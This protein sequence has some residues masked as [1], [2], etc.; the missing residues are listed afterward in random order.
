[1]SY[2]SI[3][4]ADKKIETYDDFEYEELYGYRD[5]IEEVFQ[6]YKEPTKEMIQYIV[7]RI[8]PEQSVLNEPSTCYKMLTHYSFQ[9]RSFLYCFMTVFEDVYDIMAFCDLWNEYAKQIALD[10]NRFCFAELKVSRA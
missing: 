5:L 1:M 2:H 3:R 6:K 7:E 9:Q 8:C 4:I 10:N